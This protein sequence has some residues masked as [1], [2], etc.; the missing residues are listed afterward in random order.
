MKA[1]FLPENSTQGGGS[2][3]NAIQVFKRLLEYLWRH[4]KLLALAVMFM[5]LTALTEAS[6][7]ALLSKW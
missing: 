6:F 7:A 5:I 2:D 3:F 1:S 4:K